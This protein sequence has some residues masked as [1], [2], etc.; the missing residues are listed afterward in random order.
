MCM[1]TTTKT[2]YHL[3]LKPLSLPILNRTNDIFPST[4]INILC[5][6]NVLYA[7]FIYTM[8]KNKIPWGYLLGKSVETYFATGR[9][10]PGSWVHQPHTSMF[11]N[12][13][14][15]RN[16]QISVINHNRYLTIYK[17]RTD[18]KWIYVW[19]YLSR[20][21]SRSLAHMKS[22]IY[23]NITETR[24]QSARWRKYLAFSMKTSAPAVK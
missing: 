2:M 10:K 14:H 24:A 15:Q 8:N 23:D 21:S 12:F 20:R 4:A 6:P 3:R 22:T 9:F 18:F 1:K 7:Y 19:N 13:I 11:W 16:N 17:S 5:K